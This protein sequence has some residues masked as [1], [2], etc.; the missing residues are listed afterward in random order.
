M[1]TRIAIFRQLVRDCM[2]DVPLAVAEGTPLGDA[3]RRKGMILTNSEWSTPT[4]F[5][6][7]KP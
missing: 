4:P 3:V 1:E 5:G 7:L 2:R 6:P